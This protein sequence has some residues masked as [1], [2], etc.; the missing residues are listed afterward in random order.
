MPETR[1][2]PAHWGPYLLQGDKSALPP[3]ELAA[4]DVWLAQIA[5]RTFV[6][7]LG[8]AGSGVFGLGEGRT[9]EGP[10]HRFQLSD[11]PSD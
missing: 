3:G 5:P 6:A 11:G 7:D 8:A 9:L 10:L 1:L 2:A 4:A